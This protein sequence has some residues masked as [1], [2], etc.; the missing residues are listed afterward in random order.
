MSTGVPERLL[1]ADRWN[2]RGYWEYA[3]LIQFNDA[4]LTAVGCRWN[5]PPDDEQDV[6]L[7]AL[8]SDPGYIDRAGQLIGDMEATATPW[9][10]KDP[11]LTVLLPFWK[12]RLPNAAFIVCLREPLSIARSLRER[13]GFP[14]SAALVLWHAYMIRLVKHMSGNSPTPRL[15]VLYDRLLLR[16]EEECERIAE[17]LSR[18]C[19]H[20][21]DDARA[22]EPMIGAVDATL[23]HRSDVSTVLSS[24]EATREAIEL[25]RMLE[26]QAVQPV[27]DLDIR[28]F[29]L[30]PRYR[31]DLNT[32]D[33]A[34]RRARTEIA[35]RYLDALAPLAVAGRLALPQ[36]PSSA[37]ASWHAF[38]IVLAS[39][40]ERARV[41][42]G[43]CDQGIES[44]FHFV[45]RNYGC[46]PDD[47]AISESMAGRRLRLPIY[48]GLSTDGQARVIEA[49]QRLLA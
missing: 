3:P 29:P 49:L 8:C 42:W 1:A 46:R 2:P 13:D 9:Y 30:D 32:I 35:K 5:L 10:W 27:W 22:I 45:P 31:E 12:N 41:A 38:H 17:F 25:W 47:L 16:P 37:T 39:S 44:P 21:H 19:G 36:P 43:L 15:C 4:L 40:S 6:K 26:A 23:E 7:A 20:N 24:S 28:R 34:G 11:R 18:Q 33:E 14:I 48:P